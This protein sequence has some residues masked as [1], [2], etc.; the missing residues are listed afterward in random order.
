MKY[1]ISTVQ[2]NWLQIECEFQPK[3]LGQIKIG[4][5]IWRPGRDQ[6]QK[7]AKNLPKMT[8]YQG[9]KQ[10]SIS[11]IESSVWELHC[12]ETAPIKLEYS[13]FAVQRDAG[14]SV[15]NEEMLYIN[16]VNCLVCP[17]GFEN[18]ACDLSIKFP[19]DWQ[20]ATSLRFKKNVFVARTY[21]E[22]VDSPFLAASQI[23]SFSWKNSGITFFLQGIGPSSIFNEKLVLAYQK[24]VAFQCG[25]MGEAPIKKYHFLLW[26]CPEAFYHGVQH[27]QSTLMVTGPADRECFDP[28]VGLASHEFFHA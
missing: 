3:K 19:Q 28:L 18:Q 4:L 22:L 17:Q 11:K 16:F 20:S 7:F 13:Y 27:M 2:E 1:T 23:H 6:A 26:I 9:D 5:P 24:I 14:G 8:A 10:I 25:W 21:R 12:D 15:A